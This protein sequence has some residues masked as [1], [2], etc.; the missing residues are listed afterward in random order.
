MFLYPTVLYVLNKHLEDRIEFYEIQ[1]VHFVF[2][3]QSVSLQGQ[4]ILAATARCF[5]Q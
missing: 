2:M 4:Y 1:L 5:E 3:P